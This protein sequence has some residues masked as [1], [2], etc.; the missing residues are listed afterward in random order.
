MFVDLR[1]LD[2]ELIPVIQFV[3]DMQDCGR[4]RNK[5][6]GGQVYLKI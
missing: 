2:Q 1:F 4:L 6:V 3:E 5:V